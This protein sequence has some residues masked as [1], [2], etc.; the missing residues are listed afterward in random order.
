MHA[1]KFASYG[2]W[3]M[4]AMGVLALIPAFSQTSYLLPA[5]RIETSYG[6]FLGFFPMNIL[7]KVALVG[8]GLAGILCSRSPEVI[9]SVKFSRV[10]CL[11]MGALAIMGLVPALNTFFGYWPLFR[12]EVLAHAVFAVFGGYYGYVVPA[13]IYKTEA[14]L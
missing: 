10:V 5:L 1:R 9:L 12:G 6:L 3:V 11:A 13:R 14:H 4:L 7:N 2:G 8:F